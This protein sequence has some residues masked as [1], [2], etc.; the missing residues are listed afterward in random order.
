MNRAQLIVL[1]VIAAAL[2]GGTI[3][4]GLLRLYA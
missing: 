2:F 3:A 1:S 4:Y